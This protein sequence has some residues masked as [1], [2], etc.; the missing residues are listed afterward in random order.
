MPPDRCPTDEAE[1]LADTPKARWISHAVGSI[2]KDEVNDV[3]EMAGRWP[4]EHGFLRCEFRNSCA[5]TLRTCSAPGAP[6]SAFVRDAVSRTID[7]RKSQLEFLARG[8]ASAERSR[9]C[10]MAASPC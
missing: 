4:A 10:G 5:R 6:L 8:I 2:W 3:L 9:T 1:Y 7:L